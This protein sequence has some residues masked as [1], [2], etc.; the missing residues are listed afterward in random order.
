[1]KTSSDGLLSDLFGQE[2]TASILIEKELKAL[3]ETWP[4]PNTVNSQ[5]SIIMEGSSDIKFFKRQI[6]PI[7]ILRN[8]IVLVWM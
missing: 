1:M 5:L 6:I 4:F 8:V 3:M 2:S 7:L